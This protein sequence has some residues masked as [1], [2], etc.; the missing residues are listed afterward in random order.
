M[1]PFAIYFAYVHTMPTYGDNSIAGTIRYKI[2]L[3]K[4][5]E[6]ERIILVGGS[7]SPYGT[8]CEEF[9]K[10]FNRP[11]INIGATAYLGW[12]FY[13]NILD[14][15]AREGDVVVLAPEHILLKDDAVGHITVLT[16]I[17]EKKEAW[18]H[19]PL[20]Y[21]PGLFMAHFQYTKFRIE[22]ADRSP[23]GA[24]HSH[25]G[26]KGDVIL[27]RES[28]LEEGFRSED[29]ILLK[30]ELI[31]NKNLKLINKFNKKAEEK[32]ITVLFAFAPVDELAIESSDEEN[33]AF[34][35][36][37][38]NKLD[39]PVVLDLETSMMEGKYFYDSNNHL[40]TAGAQIYT[41]NL[42]EGLK[43]FIS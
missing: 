38:V 37:V 22:Y 13:M 34:E 3:I 6:G 39:I 41:A 20:S 40:T 43:A 9:E 11:C 4:D 30:P 24:I 26:P 1:L 14:S 17:G 15:Y 21:Y 27:E 16:G 12:E 36:A 29:M 31:Y 8:V 7:S 23:N 10:A 32:G 2:D 28:E 42:I 35:T 19:V 25:F 33:K 18:K 5:T